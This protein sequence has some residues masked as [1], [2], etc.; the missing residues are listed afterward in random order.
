MRIQRMA[1]AEKRNVPC[2]EKTRGEDE[3]RYSPLVTSGCYPEFGVRRSPFL[4]VIH[5]CEGIFSLIENVST[6]VGE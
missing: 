1:F 4:C 3:K 2:Q 6:R 5:S